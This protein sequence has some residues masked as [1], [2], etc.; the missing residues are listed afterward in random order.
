MM[1]AETETNA[2]IQRTIGKPSRS[3][4]VLPIAH[5]LDATVC[6]CVIL[7]DVRRLTAVFDAPAKLL[8][9]QPRAQGLPASSRAGLY[10]RT[11]HLLLIAAVV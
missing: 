11:A 5:R 6:Y 9:A 3:A 2:L 7:P 4:M 10:A 8:K 1:Q